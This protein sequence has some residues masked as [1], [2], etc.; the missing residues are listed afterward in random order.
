MT[1]T[2]IST[3]AE[4]EALQEE[5]HYQLENDIDLSGQLWTPL[6]MAFLGMLDGDGHT[7]SGLT[8]TRA[9][10]NDTA[11][12][13]QVGSTLPWLEGG[14]VKNLI[15]TD[16]NVTAIQVNTVPMSTGAIAGST[17]GHIHHCF[18]EGSVI[19]KA[20]TGLL[21]GSISGP[22]ALVE[23]CF[24]TGSV[25][26]DGARVGGLTGNVSDLAAQVQYCYSRATVQ[27]TWTDTAG[28]IGRATGSTVKHCYSTGAVSSNST[29]RLGGFIGGNYSGAVGI[30]NFWDTQTSGRPTS[31]LATG[32]TTS[33][34]KA[35]A[36][37][38]GWDF[39]EIWDIHP[40][41]NDGYPYL[42]YFF[43]PP[44]M[45][46]RPSGLFVPMRRPS[47]SAGFLRKQ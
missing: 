31:Q 10:Q 45:R 46:R 3:R 25:A 40:A 6:N 33:Q 21:V 23:Y 20:Y 36:T 5:G 7:L 24:T 4:L 44:A 35:K 15:L 2:L 17:N 13:H 19:G 9:D 47:R 30:A 37:F 32:R 1:M 42:R 26:G 8:I 39:D 41:V 28:F 27:N 12:I 43:D 16:V 11:M 29:T 22:D 34:M 14:E 38:T 18:V